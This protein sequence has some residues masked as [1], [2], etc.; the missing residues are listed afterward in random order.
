MSSIPQSD[1]ERMQWDRVEFKT[2]KNFKLIPF[3]WLMDGWKYFCWILQRWNPV[4]DCNVKHRQDSSLNRFPTI[5]W[6]SSDAWNK[7][8][9]DVDFIRDLTV[10]NSK[11]SPP[12]CNHFYIPCNHL[13]RID[14][15]F[16]KLSPWQN[17]SV[18]H[19]NWSGLQSFL[20]PVFSY[21]T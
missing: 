6:V 7:M 11:V 13:N 1:Y 21:S 10:T 5:S 17:A 19:L 14:Q 4:S 16:S 2:A 18:S 20:V 8:I 3:V 15:I 12:S 9:R